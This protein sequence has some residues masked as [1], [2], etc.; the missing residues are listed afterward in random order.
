MRK[1][2]LLRTATAQVNWVTEEMA[3]T[4]RP[5]AGHLVAGVDFMLI[6]PRFSESI[7]FARGTQDFAGRSFRK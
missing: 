4:G 1:Q 6:R 7:A 5:D 2:H 3:A